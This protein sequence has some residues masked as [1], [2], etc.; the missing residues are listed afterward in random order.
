[1]PRTRPAVP[2]AECSTPLEAGGAPRGPVRLGEGATTAL[3]PATAEV[4]AGFWAVRREVNARTSVPQ[5][6]GLLESAGN[7]H[8]LRVAAGTAEG[9]FRGAYPFVDSD[10]YKW[11]EAASWQLAQG[12]SHA[13]TDEATGRLADEKTGRLA[14][15]VERIVA[16]VAE[17]QQPDGYLNTWFQLLKGG[18]RYQD[19]RWGHELY[20]AGHLIQAAVAHHRATG[21]TEL[22]QVARRFADHIDSVFGL[23][24]S[25]KPI[26]GVDGHPE[27]ETAL[28]EL[29]RET[30]ERRY[31][32]LAGYFVDRFGHGLLGGEAYCQDRVPLREA[33]N[34][35]GHA[36]RQLYLL[37]AATD[38][39]AE[40]G[41]AELRSV[42]E[43]LWQAM[44][45]TKTHL[46]G[47]LGAH[48]DEEDFGDP[49]ELPNERAY[50][51]TCAAIASIQWSWRMALLT[52]ETR[53]SDLIE[54]TL[55]NGF[56]AGVSLDGERWLYVNPLQVRD[57]HTDSGGD[58]SARR[59]RWFRCACCPPNAMRLLAS[60]EHYLASTDAGGLQIH[61]YVSGRYTG[62]VAGA[63]V[64]VTAETDYPW[65]GTIGLT[66]E[67]TP[68]DRPWALSLRI[69][70]WCR[71]YRVRCG[72]T[73][74]DRTDA[75][76]ADGWLRLERSWAPGDQVV[77]EL[78][79]APRLTEADPRVDAVRGCVA[80]ERGPLVYC[81]EQAD[82]PGGGLDDLVI[83]TTA[84]PAVKDRPDLLGGVVTVVAGGYRRSTPDR[85]W[86]PYACA[87]SGASTGTTTDAPSTGSSVELTAIPYYAWANR[88]DGGMRV[89]L[90]TG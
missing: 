58:Q 11:L 15:E 77:L 32:D 52:G 13:D 49:Y 71:E 18:E 88:Q 76:A 19:L 66:V 22:L 31:L 82:H 28:V 81:L 69:P 53:Y 4:C 30:G 67:Q 70:Q 39:A 59:T 60:L 84:P 85:G 51:E 17:A 29:Y 72:D 14:D 64:T 73:T 65:H 37:A 12:A 87:E 16:L 27:V 9:E 55:Y 48:H 3:A 23:P 7:L 40:T 20:C 47:G 25:G 8:N 21:R 41:D 26:D 2:S 78:V 75:P 79:L 86:W 45:A 36:V 68:T 35:E 80:I 44:T 63:P 10:V 5:G 83:D 43:R 1:M 74:Y 46:T 38:L 33:T 57:G 89:W 62:D 61:Q 42:A 90:P 34:V 50:C 54:R 56:L 24:E 6:P